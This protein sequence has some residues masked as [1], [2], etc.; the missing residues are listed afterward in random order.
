MSNIFKNNQ[1][2]NTKESKA[3]TFSKSN[4]YL[5]FIGICT[6]ILGYIVMISGEVDSFKSL[7][8]APIML[9]TGYIIFIPLALIYN[10]K[11]RIRD[12]SSVG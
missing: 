11:K 7:V 3:W 1:T 12:R 8:I 9:F 6:I 10:K 2:L 5:F 4:Y